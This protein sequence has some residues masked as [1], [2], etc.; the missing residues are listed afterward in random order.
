MKRRIQERPELGVL[1]ITELH[2]LGC[3]GVGRRVENA[4]TFIEGRFQRSL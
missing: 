4:I 2:H 3:G 1:S